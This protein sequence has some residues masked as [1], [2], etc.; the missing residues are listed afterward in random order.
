MG[1]RLSS[2]S[3][4]TSISHRFI[5]LDLSDGKLTLSQRVIADSDDMLS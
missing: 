3:A 5:T 1:P 4:A 2:V